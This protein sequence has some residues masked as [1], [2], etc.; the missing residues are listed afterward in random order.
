MGIKL[1]KTSRPRHMRTR[2]FW[3]GGSV[4]PGGGG[5][6]VALADRRHSFCFTEGTEEM[7]FKREKKEEV[8]EKEDWKKKKRKRD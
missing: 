8:R 7:T 2:S 5:S 4:H 3:R 1:R 6:R